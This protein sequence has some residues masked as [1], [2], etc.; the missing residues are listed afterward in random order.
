MTR[1]FV[2]GHHTP[3]LHVLGVRSPRQ[4]PPSVVHTWHRPYYLLD[5]LLFVL[6]ARNWEV[7]VWRMVSTPTKSILLFEHIRKKLGEIS[8]SEK[9][10]IYA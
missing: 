4:V 9:V 3:Y 8:E 7:V 6:S 5:I 2:K 1:I 10:P